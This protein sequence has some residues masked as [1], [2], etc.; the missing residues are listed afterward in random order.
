MTT[1]ATTDMRILRPSPEARRRTILFA[2]I[3]A[4]PL[5]FIVL[6]NSLIQPHMAPFYL[7]VLMLVAALLVP[8]LI[9]WSTVTRLEFGG[10]RYRYI[11]TFI[12]RE[13]TTDDVE[14]VLAVDEVFYGL[15]G[16]RMLFVVGRT[17]RRL[18]RLNSVVFDT[19][20]LEAIVN[21]LL[22]RGVSLTHIPERLTPG[23]LDRREPGI[24]RWHEAHR[25][26]FMVLLVVGVLLVAVVAFVVIIAAF[27]A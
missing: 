23:E 8:Y 16:A 24:L 22:A 10:G 25:V 9:W 26:A 2:F 1:P 11:T 13:F 14:R 7:G 15:N 19:A 20:Q 17:R 4:I 18:L 21:D 6:M 27:V 5:V 12:R 3:P